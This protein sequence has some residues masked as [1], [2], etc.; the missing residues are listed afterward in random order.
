MT[1]REALEIG[2]LGGAKLLGRTDIGAL[3][4]GMAAD[5]AIF[6]LNSIAFAGARHDPVAALAFCGPINAAYTIV[7]GRVIVREGRVTT[8]DIPVLLRRHN[9]LAA[10]LIDG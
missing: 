5:L 6:D 10:Q 7:N 1:A 8:I 3:S 4:P 2:T 9:Q